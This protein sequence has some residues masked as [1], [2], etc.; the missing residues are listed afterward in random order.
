MSLTNAQI[1]ELLALRAEEVAGDRQRA[2]RRAARAAFKWPDEVT[3]MLEAER[4]LIDLKGIGAK[5]SG[6]IRTWIE[7]PPDIL[8][9]P[10]IRD[11]FRS[12]AEARAIL[13]A[14]P[15]WA[16]GVKGDLQMHSEESDGKVP[17]EEM[18]RTGIDLGYSYIAITDH[19]KGLK[20]AGGMD[21]EGFADQ[22]RRIDELN[23]RLVDQGSDFKVL[24]GIEM[25]LSPDGSGDM[26]RDCLGALDLVLGSF[27]SQLRRKEDQTDRYI[28]GIEN[29]DVDV[30]GHP[31]CRIYN[32]R[33]GLLAD[34]KTVLEAAADNG[35]AV[36]IDGFPD[37]QD[38]NVELLEIARDAGCWIS[39][40]TDAH[41]QEEMRYLP[42][43]LAAAISAG[44]PREKILNFMTADE[45]A[46]WVSDRRG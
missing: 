44:I 4:P 26:E 36:E 6:L 34:W 40:G 24:K 39:M 31:R 25:N 37:R 8:D 3:D 32:F 14:H 18:A 5:L 10:P 28:A 16:E 33:V 19:S 41:N 12:F 9:P 38:L 15:G 30:L 11:G 17:I 29:P 7:D 21:E 22:G 46:A 2:Y 27:H 20:I 45:L 1:G 42:V 43:A 23:G 13:A 35:T